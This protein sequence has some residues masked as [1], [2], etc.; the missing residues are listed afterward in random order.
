MVALARREGHQ[1]DGNELNGGAWLGHG[2]SSR[3]GSI[4]EQ[5]RGGRSVAHSEPVD[6]HRWARG[7]REVAEFDAGVRGSGGGRRGRRACCA[8]SWLGPVVEGDAAGHDV[9]RGLVGEGRGQWW[10]R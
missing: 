3:S 10:P 5:K 1:V 6:V 7:R 8:G 4:R 9:A 2:G